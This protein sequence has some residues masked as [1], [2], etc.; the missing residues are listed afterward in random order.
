MYDEEPS[1]GRVVSLIEAWRFSRYR[2]CVRVDDEVYMNRV[3]TDT[4]AFCNEEAAS[5]VINNTPVIDTVGAAD[6][7]EVLLAA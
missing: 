7:A 1:S 3:F 2:A 4:S 5:E 6:N